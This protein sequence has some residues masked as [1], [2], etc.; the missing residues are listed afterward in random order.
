[1]TC[2][3]PLYQN[4]NRAEFIVRWWY[5]VPYSEHKVMLM[6]HEGSIIFNQ[7]P[8]LQVGKLPESYINP[9]INEDPAE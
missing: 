9:L 4:R 1:M 5:Q 2:L 6:S 3:R 7:P 8:G